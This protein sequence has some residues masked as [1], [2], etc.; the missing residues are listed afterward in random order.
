MQSKRDGF[1]SIGDQP[2]GAQRGPGIEPAKELE[3]LGW[4]A[5]GSVAVP[6]LDLAGVLSMGGR[7][8]GIARKLI[9]SFPL[10]GNTMA[11]LASHGGLGRIGPTGLL[12]GAE[13]P[14]LAAQARL[15]KIK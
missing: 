9:L 4:I 13:P 3:R 10:K 8:L 12:P 1:V 2:L 5:R 15:V 7:A 6:L 14:L 11:N